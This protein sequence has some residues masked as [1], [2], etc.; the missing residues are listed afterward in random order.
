MRI[1]TWW[2]APTKSAASKERRRTEG[3]HVADHVLDEQRILGSL[4]TIERLMSSPTI[5]TG[6]ARTIFEAYQ[7]LPPP[8]S[9]IRAPADTPPTTHG[10]SASVRNAFDGC[11]SNRR[12]SSSRCVS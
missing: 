4:L 9:T 10:T 5:V 1:R 7:Q 8:M 2:S 12:R 11:C 3:L 6:A